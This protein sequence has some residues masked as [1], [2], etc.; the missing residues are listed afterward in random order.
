MSNLIEVFNKLKLNLSNKTVLQERCTTFKL[1]K[2]TPTLKV[3]ESEHDHSILNW[4]D[5]KLLVKNEA[6]F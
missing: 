5:V 3:A 6:F 2:S 4:N 1:F